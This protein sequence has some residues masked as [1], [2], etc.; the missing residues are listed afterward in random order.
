MEFG[1]IFLLANV[2]EFGDIFL[3]ANVMEFRR[4]REHQCP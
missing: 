4:I 2:M 3:L 1:D